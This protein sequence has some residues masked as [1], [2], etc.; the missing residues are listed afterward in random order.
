MQMRINTRT[1]RY[2]KLIEGEQADAAD[3]LEAVRRLAERQQQIQRITRDLE[4][5]KNR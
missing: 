1:Q 2:G 5:G 4:M 3:L